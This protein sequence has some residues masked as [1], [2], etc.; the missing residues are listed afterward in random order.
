MEAALLR[1][2]A[3]GRSAP[4]PGIDPARAL[5]MEHGPRLFGWLLVLDG[6]EPDADTREFLFVL[7]GQAAA[8]LHQ[9]ELLEERLRGERLATIGRMI[10]SIVHDFRNPMTSVKGYASLLAEELPPERRAQ[11]VRLITEETERMGSMIEEILEF[12]RG[13]RA[14]LRPRP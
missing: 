8:G 9:L 6:P 4:P 13:E 12:T 5:A 7:A 11:Y 14:A 2:R 3:E 1:L 10:S